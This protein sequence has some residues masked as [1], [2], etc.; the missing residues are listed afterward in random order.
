MKWILVILLF[1]LFS[2]KDN[3]II[4]PDGGYTFINTDT[5]EDKS[6]PFFPVRDSMLT[7]DSMNAVFEEMYEMKSFEER[8]LSLAPSKKEI[9]RLSISSG[10]NPY[11]FFTLTDGKII[12]KKCEFKKRKNKVENKLTSIEEFQFE[13]LK[14]H[15]PLTNEKREKPFKLNWLHF[16][17]SIL[18]LYPELKEA[19]YYKKLMLKAYPVNN[20]CNINTRIIRLP[21]HTYKYLIKKI[22]NSGYWKMPLHFDCDDGSTDG[23]GISLEANNGQKYNLVASAICQDSSNKFT[24]ACQEIINYAHYE[25]EIRVAW[26]KE[27]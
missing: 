4:Y 7:R 27:R 24:L 26:D 11:Y 17:D 22:N 5:I 20:E 18:K 6:F 25:K 16:K 15:Y 12:A 1:I 2:C 8:N 23:I 19:S 21:N 9:F 14:M 10:F 13:Y 3:P